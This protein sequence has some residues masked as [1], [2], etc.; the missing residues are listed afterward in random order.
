MENIGIREGLSRELL[1]GRPPAPVQDA[2]KNGSAR[3]RAAPEPR[4]DVKPEQSE[5]VKKVARGDE[6]AIRQVAEAMNQYME[7]MSYSLQF[8]PSKD[9]AGTVVVNVLDS[10]GNIVRRI[11]PENMAALSSRIG[12]SIGMLV[13]VNR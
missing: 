10:K 13:N 11:P 3:S 4:Q 1:P 8:I 12:S 7:R 2:G 9:T 6:E 5:F